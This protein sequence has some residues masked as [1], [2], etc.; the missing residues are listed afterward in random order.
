MQ[1]VLEHALAQ[2]IEVLHTEFVDLTLLTSD[3]W[4][5]HLAHRATCR[6]FFSWEPPPTF[7]K[8]NF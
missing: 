8:I 4:D 2:A 6:V 5:S 7:L 3:H 1:F